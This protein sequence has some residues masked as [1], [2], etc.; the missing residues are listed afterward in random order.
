MLSAVLILLALAAWGVVH[1]YTASLTAKA[2]ARQWLGPRAAE[3]LYRLA[4]NAVS[5]ITFLPVMALT[6][7]LPDTPLYRFPG[8]L[9]VF[10]VPL[11]LLSALAGLVV[12]WQVDLFHF[13]GLRQLGSTGAPEAP[14]ARLYTGGAYGWVRHPLYFFSLVFLWLTP[15]MTVNTLVFNLGATAYFYIGSIFEERKLVAEFGDVYREHQR[16][17]PR[18][19]PW[20]GRRAD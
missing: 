6:S 8:W 1:S 19:I 14:P 3:G 13:L 2:R 9:A 7:L 20:P 4:Y 16:R 5:L 17:V 11:Q 15:I 18:L 10:S 12:L